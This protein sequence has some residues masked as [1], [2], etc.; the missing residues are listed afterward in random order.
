M[1]AMNIYRVSVLL[2]LV[3]ASF[4][5]TAC[6]TTKATIDTTVKFFSST[7]PGEIF[8]ED[9]LVAEDQKL[10][11][12]VG[13]GFDSLQQD[14]AKGEGEYL[15]SLERLLRISPHHHAEFAGYAQQHFDTLFTSDFSTD[16]TAHLTT[17][18][19]L[20]QSLSK[21][22]RLA[23]WRTHEARVE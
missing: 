15:V 18:A 21:D 10:N 11:F 19:S 9:G 8:T 4:L 16:R 3:S 23:K 5:S 13:V 1:I 12:F 14:I 6:N 7:T 20:E 17:V 2:A 22:G